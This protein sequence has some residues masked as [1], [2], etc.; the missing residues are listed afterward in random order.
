MPHSDNSA[1]TVSSWPLSTK[2][3]KVKEMKMMM[4]K[5]RKKGM[6]AFASS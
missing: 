3:D 5:E 1:R 2:Y 6:G 4:K